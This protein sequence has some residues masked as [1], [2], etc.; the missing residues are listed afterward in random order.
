[1]KRTI[2]CILGAAAGLAAL[3][4]AQDII[5]KVVGGTRPVLAVPDFRGAGEAAPHMSVFNATLYADLDNSGLFKMAAKSMFPLEVP[6]RPEDFRPPLAPPTAK[7]GAAAQPVRQGPWLTDWS[8][9]PVGASHL[10]FGYAATQGDQLVLSGWLYDVSQPNVSSAQLIG[11]RYLGPVSAAGAKTV[12]HEFAADIIKQFGGETL[13][14]SKIY[15]ISDRTGS[16]EV[17]S[18]DPDGSSQKQ[19]TSY[20]STCTTPA[21]SLDGTKIAFT[22]YARGIPGIFIHSLET[23]RRLPFVNPQATIT[24]SPGFTPDGQKL[25]YSSSLSGYAQLYIGNPDGSQ[26]QRITQTRAVETEPKVSPKGGSI[27]FVSGRSGTP[28]VYMMG[29]DGSSAERLTS[30]EGDATNP[31]WHPNGQLIAF[32]WSR[33]F[34]PGKFNVFLMDV[35][36]RRYDQLTHGEGKN[37]N[38]VWAPDGRHI[39][40]QSNRSGRSQIWTMLADGTKVQQL[41]TQGSNTMPVWAK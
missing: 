36:S 13:L 6:Q 27:V 17:W 4:P 24:Y 12:A 38:P 14:N 1:M 5:E 35:A 34:E 33:G 9:P 32:A 21:V 16:K 7:K 19:F 8:Q 25:L 22:T 15:F 40:F 2:P 20:K 30:G 18:M 11:K 31:S 3:L 39:V 23:G 37:E 41:T 29:M 10:A 28:Q 26:S